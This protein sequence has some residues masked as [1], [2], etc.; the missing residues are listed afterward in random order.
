MSCDNFRVSPDLVK[1]T[2][3]PTT[4][5]DVNGTVQLQCRAHVTAI[6]G[7]KILLG[8]IQNEVLE[9]RYGRNVSWQEY[10]I[11]WEHCVLGDTQYNE[12]N[13]STTGGIST[14]FNCT[15][16]TVDDG[17][18]NSVLLTSVIGSYRCVVYD[19]GTQLKYSSHHVQV[20]S[21]SNDV[22]AIHAIMGNACE[23]CP[24]PQNISVTYRTRYIGD[25]D[26]KYSKPVLFCEDRGEGG[27][28]Q[29]FRNGSPL[30]NHSNRLEATDFGVY[31]CYSYNRTTYS[32]YRVLPFGCINPVADVEYPILNLTR[33]METLAEGKLQFCW[34][35][36]THLGGLSSSDIT[37]SVKLGNLSKINSK[38]VRS[39]TDGRHC[40]KANLTS[41]NKL[42]NTLLTKIII[43][44]TAHPNHVQVP[45]SL[46]T[47]FPA[48]NLLSWLKISVEKTCVTNT[49]MM[50]LTITNLSFRPND[51][52]ID[53]Y[54]LTRT[55]NASDH[56]LYQGYN[57][58]TLKNCTIN[59]HDLVF[60][61][62]S[63][64]NSQAK[65]KSLLFQLW[66]EGPH[67][68]SVAIGNMV[69]VY[70]C[71]YNPWSSVAY[72]FSQQVDVYVCDV[73][74]PPIIINSSN[75]THKSVTL[76]WSKP[77]SR[78]HY[79][80]DID[81]YVIEQINGNRRVTV[82]RQLEY[83]FTDLNPSTNYTFQV[84]AGN[85]DGLGSPS[86]EFSISTEDYFPS[87]PQNVTAKIGAGWS[88]VVSWMPPAEKNGE[89]SHYKVKAVGVGITNMCKE[90]VRTENTSIMITGL[91]TCVQYKVT[92]RASTTAGY[93]NASHPIVSFLGSSAVCNSSIV[94]TIFIQCLTIALLASATA[95]L[96]V[97]C[98][99]KWISRRRYELLMRKSLSLEEP[100]VMGA[101]TSCGESTL[102]DDVTQYEMECYVSMQTDYITQIISVTRGDDDPDGICMEGN[103]GKTNQANK[104]KM[105]NNAY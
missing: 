4:A 50:Q 10:R 56:S 104:Y 3:H 62:P 18:L 89:I 54:A 105:H 82:S 37:Y 77:A 74:L 71:S 64:D 96:A 24:E 101:V 61:K 90:E 59:M 87:R 102:G 22:N 26:S 86:E 78:H 100:S 83:T 19:W 67:S 53:I 47:E 84:F 27:Y 99:I 80:P 5:K 28:Y 97:F 39:N 30:K 40:Y 72:V 29:W 23:T 35:Q 41:E 92:V 94:A 76:Q 95:I 34:N 57:L 65:L 31:V 7:H 60:D 36:P 2:E 98:I 8:S 17:E 103:P 21:G 63:I 49:S 69:L 9:L 58:M 45:P 13:C 25:R 43:A 81:Y 68:V 55:R 73:P 88:I 11:H 93:G 48:M 46:A 32:T 14:E 38:I 1:F 6:G 51:R 16:N 85:R 44:I 12:I 33:D 70:F 42:T 52:P 66:D 91:E 20:I 15:S 79:I 75:I